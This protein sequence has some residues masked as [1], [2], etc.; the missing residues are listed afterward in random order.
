MHDEET[1]R[2]MYHRLI[3]LVSDIKS[4]GSMEWD[5]HKMTKKLLRAFT[6]RNPTIVTM[7]RNIPNSRSRHLI[8]FLVKFS[9]KSWLGGM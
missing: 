4:L 2:Q 1:V 7:I 5:D 9:I 6:L 3:I 8:N